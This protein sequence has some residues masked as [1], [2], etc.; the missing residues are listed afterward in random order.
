[1]L[2][3]LPGIPAY[4]L[5]EAL[6]KRH[7]N[8]ASVA[9]RR[10]F[11][12]NRNGVHVRRNTHSAAFVRKRKEGFE[13][14]PRDIA[15][16]DIRNIR[17]VDRDDPELLAF[18][19]KQ[20]QLHG[21]LGPAGENS[22]SSELGQ[23]FEGVMRSRLA[24]AIDIR[25]E[26][27]LGYES[28]QP[29]TPGYEPCFIELDAVA[30]SIECGALRFFEIKTTRSQSKLGKG[31]KQLR[32]LRSIV[33]KSR[34]VS[35]G[36]CLIWIDSGISEDQY[37]RFCRDITPMGWGEMVR[38][39]NEPIVRHDL[40]D[41]VKLSMAEALDW[42]IEDGASGAQTLWE[43]ALAEQQEQQEQ[44]V[45]PPRRPPGRYVTGDAGGIGV[46]GT[47][48]SKALEKPKRG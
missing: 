16:A 40:P 37:E 22:A 3:A 47:E 24:R 36:L 29:G 48:L 39:A 46:F 34:R 27:F 26:R 13:L 35:V 15:R 23:L 11:T 19:S 21:R 31:L 6:S 9:S 4:H 30:G 28:Q 42:A 44:Q 32:R 8:G 20:V 7:P 1:M 18:T 45:A 14:M 10:L 43:R 25:D 17:L 12:V 41:V 2:T 33:S 38:R 5:T